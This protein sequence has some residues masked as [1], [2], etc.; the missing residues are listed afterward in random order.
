[1]KIAIFS[2]TTEGRRLSEMLCSHA[3]RHSVFVATEYGNSVMEQ[4]EYAKV[5]V[6]RLDRDQMIRH[7]SEPGFGKEDVLV[8]ATHPYARD[9]S[10]NIEET[11]G[12]LGCRLIRVQRG[13]SCN[14]RADELINLR[15]K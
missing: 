2:G 13:S 5:H 10:A 7:L 6:G 1:M 3:V 4:N 8:D 14:S 11:A 15:N 9:V 12:K